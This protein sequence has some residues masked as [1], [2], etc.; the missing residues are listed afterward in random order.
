ML[1]LGIIDSSF[2]LSPRHPDVPAWDDEPHQ[3]WQERRMEVYAAQVTSMDRNIGRIIDRL[4]IMGS[5]ITLSS[6]SMTM[7]LPWWNTR[8][9]RRAHGHGRLLQT[10]NELSRL[11]ISRT[12]CPVPKAVGNPT[13][14]GGPML[15]IPLP[16]TSNTTTKGARARL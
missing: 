8:L 14:T 11:G 9:E 4:E 15:P 7:G 3:D 10:G 16:T 6:T 5:L 12:S 13:A 2:K 1:E